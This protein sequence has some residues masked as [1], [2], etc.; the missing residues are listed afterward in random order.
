MCVCVCLESGVGRDKR[1]GSV[2]LPPLIT[3]DQSG[4]HAAAA[5]FTISVF[6]HKTEWSGEK[7][8]EEEAVKI[9]RQESGGG[10]FERMM[11]CLAKNA[12]VCAGEG[13]G[14]L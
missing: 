6:P 12:F 4:R 2:P 5:R 1:K 10:K 11:V 13:R 7:E 9:C 8:G 14:I 3:K